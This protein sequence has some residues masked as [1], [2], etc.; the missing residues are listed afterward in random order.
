MWIFL[1]ASERIKVRLPMAPVLPEMGRLQM[2]E[3]LQKT[4]GGISFEGRLPEI[5]GRPRT[6]GLEFSVS[7]IEE[8]NKAVF[9]GVMWNGH[10]RRAEVI[11]G[12]KE[13]IPARPPTYNRGLRPQAP[14]NNNWRALSGNIGG[15]GVWRGKSV[16]QCFNC[17]GYGHTKDV[18][19]SVSRKAAKRIDGVKSGK[20]KGKADKIVDEEGFELVKGKRRITEVEENETPTLGPAQRK[21][22][23]Q[24]LRQAEAQNIVGNLLHTPLQ[25]RR[26]GWEVG[27][28]R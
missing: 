2:R 3:E 6:T 13:S 15:A 14:W 5:W 10:K 22:K 23:S 24:E 20:E 27:Q 18:C 19:S 4:N 25:T 17:Q 28:M 1:D 11:T 9:K 8:A 21:Q 16:V 7:N 12:E 26:Q